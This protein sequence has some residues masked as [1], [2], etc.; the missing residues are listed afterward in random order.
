MVSIFSLIWKDLKK[1]HWFSYTAWPPLGYLIFCPGLI[2][3]VRGCIY[4]NFPLHTGSSLLHKCTYESLKLERWTAGV[5]DDVTL[6]KSWVKLASNL[7]NQHEPFQVAHSC[8]KETQ[9]PSW[10]WQNHHNTTCFLS[11]L[12]FFRKV[13]VIDL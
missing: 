5:S 2:K 4:P 11:F 7:A 6:S 8:K 12:F 13:K 1:L 10:R 3:C 9:M